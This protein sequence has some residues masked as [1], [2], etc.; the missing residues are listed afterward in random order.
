MEAL[1]EFW[2]RTAPRSTAFSQA[3]AVAMAMTLLD[4]HQQTLRKIA[5]GNEPEAAVAGKALE[6]KPPVWA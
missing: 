4:H 2:D 1:Q 5:E 3:D 6:Y